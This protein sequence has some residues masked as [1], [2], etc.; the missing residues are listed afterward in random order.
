M[1]EETANQLNKDKSKDH[2]D[3]FLLYTGRDIGESQKR[4]NTRGTI[5]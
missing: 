1:L 5:I 2:S 3:E 4:L